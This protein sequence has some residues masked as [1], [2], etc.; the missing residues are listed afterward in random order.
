MDIEMGTKK[1]PKPIEA[2]YLCRNRQCMACKYLDGEH[3]KPCCGYSRQTG[4]V[5]GCEIP[6]C[7]KFEAAKR[8]R[9]PKNLTKA[10]F[11]NWYEAF[12]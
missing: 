6:F 12:G 3:T 10:D 1:E 5:R 7:T 8:K 2:S 4:T 9:K 11:T